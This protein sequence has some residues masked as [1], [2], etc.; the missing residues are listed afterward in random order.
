MT[1]VS[2]RDTIRETRIAADNVMRTRGNRRPMIPPIRRIGRNRDERKAH[3]EHGESDFARPGHA[4][5]TRPRP[6]AMCRE[7]FSITTIASSTTKPVEI[8]KP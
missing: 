5:A 7:M 2:V 8:V 6:S 4:A 3:R 1:G